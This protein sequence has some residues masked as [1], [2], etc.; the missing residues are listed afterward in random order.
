[1][2]TPRAACVIEIAFHMVVS[3]DLC[4]HSVVSVFAKC[5][6]VYSKAIMLIDKKLCTNRADMVPILVEDVCVPQS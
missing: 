6:R 3:W 4:P 2:W 5:V 1:M